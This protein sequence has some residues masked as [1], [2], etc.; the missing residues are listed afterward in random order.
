M[1]YKG[2]GVW[3]CRL[4]TLGYVGYL[5]A[6]GTMATFC[7]LLCAISMLSF[8]SCWLVLVVLLIII[9]SYYSIAQALPYF[10]DEDPQEIVLDEFVAGLV[11]F[12]CQP[13]SA[14]ALIVGFLLFRFFDIYKYGLVAWAERLPGAAGVLADDFCAALLSMICV[15]II[16]K[17]ALL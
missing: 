3:Y 5:P 1:S 14:S 17:L 9:F 13:H 16:H 10:Y 4:S 6:P 2:L 7:S 11:L 15:Y 12:L 8:M